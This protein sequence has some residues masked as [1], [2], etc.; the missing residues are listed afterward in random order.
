MYDRQTQTLWSHFD[1]QAILGH[2]EG[3]RLEYFPTAIVSWG[4]WRKANPNARVLS[5]N[6]GVYSSVSYNRNPYPG[7]LDRP[8]VLSSRFLAGEVDATLPEKEQI[9]GVRLEGEALAIQRSH[10]IQQGVLEIDLGTEPI[11]V[12][13][14]PGTRSGIDAQNHAESQDVGS[15]AVFSRT[16]EGKTLS[17]ERIPTGFRDKT[18][19]SIFNVLGQAISGELEGSRLTQLEFLDTFWFSWS[20]FEPDSRLLLA[21]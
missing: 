21:G 3:S 8:G 10:L 12:W 13:H 7:Y 4:E 11:T 5:R 2:L 6:T 14:L 20:F 16:F 18:T 17:F 15:V 19:G 1:G 9:I